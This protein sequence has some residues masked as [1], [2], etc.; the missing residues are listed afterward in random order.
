MYIIFI[1]YFSLL[2]AS[3]QTATISAGNADGTGGSSL[4][5]LQSPTGI[6]VGVD[7]S[8]Y[9]ADFSNNRVIKFSNES[10][11]GSIVAGTGVG[12]STVSQLYGPTGLYVDAS[13]NVYVADAYNYR[14]MFWP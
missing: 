1:V 6:S 4:S 8:L 14:V 7:N 9:V 10:L 11:T 5:A 13:S 12:G 3:L 2:V